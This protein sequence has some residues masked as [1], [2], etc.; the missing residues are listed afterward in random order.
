[1]F[2]VKTL[3][4]PVDNVNCTCDYPDNLP[5]EWKIHNNNST[6]DCVLV[7]TEEL[8]EKPDKNDTQCCS[9]QRIVPC[10]FR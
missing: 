7:Y 3:V 4:L 9:I 1:M 5:S 8:P 2:I 10:F 6:F